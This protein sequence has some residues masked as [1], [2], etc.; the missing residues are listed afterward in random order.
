MSGA[1]IRCLKDE[2]VWEWTSDPDLANV[3]PDGIVFADTREEAQLAF[4]ARYP[5]PVEGLS[6]FWLDFT[7]G[8]HCDIAKI[9]DGSRAHIYSEPMYPGRDVDG[10]CEM[11]ARYGSVRTNFR[12]GTETWRSRD[13]RKVPRSNFI[14]SDCVP[15]DD[16]DWSWGVIVHH[17]P[18]QCKAAQQAAATRAKNVGM[19][20]ELLDRFYSAMHEKLRS[21]DSSLFHHVMGGYHTK[22]ERQWSAIAAIETIMPVFVYVFGK[23]AYRRLPSFQVM[24]KEWRR[25]LLRS[26]I[27]Y[28]ACDSRRRWSC[29]SYMTSRFVAW[30]NY[31]ITIRKPVKM[32]LDIPSTPSIFQIPENYDVGAIVRKAEEQEKEK[33]RREARK[34]RRV[35][36]RGKKGRRRKPRTVHKNKQAVQ[37]EVQTG[38]PVLL[39]IDDRIQSR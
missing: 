16:D 7:Y 22:A 29:G 1:Y 38:S 3:D 20:A 19:S 28:G 36:S 25:L 39:G 2:N 10:V 35:K 24:K 37:G 14:G 4:E 5:C 11:A 13:K 33:K 6:L 31:E 15:R 32:E 12:L 17:R 27:E 26:N 23:F 30:M 34:K 9:P 21:V 8:Y 18:K